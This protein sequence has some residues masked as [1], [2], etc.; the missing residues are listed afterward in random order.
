M[1][2]SVASDVQ[3][4]QLVDAFKQ[5]EVAYAQ[6]DAEGNLVAKRFFYGVLLEG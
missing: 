6:G 2:T 1:I 4:E 3:L 5:L